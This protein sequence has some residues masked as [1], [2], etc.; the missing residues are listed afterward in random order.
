MIRNEHACPRPQWRTAARISIT[1]AA[2]ARRCEPGTGPWGN[3]S[4]PARVIRNI[5]LGFWRWR[6]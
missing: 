5:W 3:A 6:R 2:A 1:A 4:S